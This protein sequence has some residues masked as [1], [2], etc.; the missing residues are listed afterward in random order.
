MQFSAVLHTWPRPHIDMTK[1]IEEE[2]WGMMAY[3][4]TE[5]QAMGGLARLRWSLHP[6]SGM[7]VE[8]RCI[9]NATLLDCCLGMPRGKRE[10]KGGQR[11]IRRALW[12]LREK[13]VHRVAAAPELEGALLETRLQPTQEKPLWRACSGQ[14]ALALL[15]KRGLRPE[16]TWLCLKTPRVDRDVLRCARLLAR[17]VR[18]LTVRA[19]VGGE[20]LAEELYEEYGIA[21]QQSVPPEYSQLCL[22]LAGDPAEE[23][24]I[25]LDG[26]ADGGL[27]ALAPEW[28]REQKPAGLAD[29]LY[30]ALLL[31]SGLLR[32]EEIRVVAPKT[33]LDTAGEGPYND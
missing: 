18:Y 15:A 17:R 20:A 16:Q 13:G 32:P 19:P 30:G 33:T 26:R 1:W 12:V 8:T 2:R 25:P 5:E 3:F 9:R 28:A 11:A 23:G 14:A 6:E 29:T 10:T 22:C 7:A 4:Q 31:Q 21:L 24:I 27:L